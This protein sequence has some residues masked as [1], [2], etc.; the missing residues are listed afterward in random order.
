[1]ND[2]PEAVV[3]L[4]GEVKARPKQGDVL[5]DKGS[6]GQVAGR[7]VF[8]LDAGHIR[9]LTMKIKSEMNLGG[10]L[11]MI[12]SEDIDL[13]R[14]PGNPLNIN[15]IQPKDA[16]PVAKG[17]VIVSFPKVLLSDKNPLDPAAKSRGVETYARTHPVQLEAGKTY[18]IEMRQ[19]TD[20]EFDPFL[21]LLD[22]SG[23]EVAFDD[24]SGGGLNARIVYQAKETGQFRIVA[25]TFQPRQTGEYSLTVTAQE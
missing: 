5:I 6:L 12:R 25:T 16:P 7:A 18:V 13:S 11:Q 14:Q 21:R 8:D 1:V 22:P 2:R 19:T 24:D 23:K 4:T 10:G 3:R 15:P 20:P 17:K 9:Q